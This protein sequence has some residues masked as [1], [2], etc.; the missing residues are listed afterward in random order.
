MG[1]RFGPIRQVMWPKNLKIKKKA[2]WG[3]H[4]KIIK[5]NKLK[6]FMYSA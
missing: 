2:H 6:F 5:I 4:K 3:V 1:R